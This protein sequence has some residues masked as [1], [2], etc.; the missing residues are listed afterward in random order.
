MS[1]LRCVR[2]SSF[3]TAPARIALSLSSLL[4]TIVAGTTAVHASTLAIHQNALTTVIAKRLFPDSGRRLLNGSISSCNYAYLERPAVT[5][6]DGRLF[7]RMHLVAQ[8]GINV[9]GHCRGAGDSFMTT[10]SG[11][12]YVTADGISIRDFRLEEGRDLYKGFLDPLLRRQVPALLSVN[13]R[14]QLARG[15]QNQVPEFRFSV[16]QLAM[17][18]ATAT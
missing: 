15:L 6:R 1:R 17:Q 8:A 11:Q 4:L 13:V 10:I 7:L 18:D 3:R 2:S 9:S 12:P 14:D 5:L 16:A